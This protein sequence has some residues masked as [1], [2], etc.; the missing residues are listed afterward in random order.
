MAIA[1]VMMNTAAPAGSK[2]DPEVASEIAEVAAGTLEP[3]QVKEYN[4]DDD[5][6][7]TRAIRA[8]AVTSDKIAQHAVTTTHYEAG[9]VDT[10]ALGPESVTAAKAGTGVVTSYDAAGNAIASRD[11]YLT[12]AEYALISTPDPNTTYYIS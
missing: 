6:V 12:A 2:F 5:A 10:A 7:A 4:L 11:V 8:G 9:S 3:N 1:T